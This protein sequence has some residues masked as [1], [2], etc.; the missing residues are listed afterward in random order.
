MRYFPLFLDMKGKTILIVG[1]GE[2]ALRK[3]RLFAKTEATI[4]VVAPALVDELAAL[5][6]VIWKGKT[7]EAGHLV[8]VSLLISADTTPAIGSHRSGNGR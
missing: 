4:H 3:A 2:E 8:G 5:P 7:F 6:A 1:G